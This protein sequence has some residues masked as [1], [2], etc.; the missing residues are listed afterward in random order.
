MLQLA[1]YDA[2][3]APPQIVAAV[4]AYRFYRNMAS[5][6]L[7]ADEMNIR[8]INVSDEAMT[9]RFIKDLMSRGGTYDDI[10]WLVHHDVMP[11]SDVWLWDDVQVELAEDDGGF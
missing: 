7:F 10:Q 8:V 6:P 4:Q 2:T 9:R 11:R 5:T 3:D 1:N